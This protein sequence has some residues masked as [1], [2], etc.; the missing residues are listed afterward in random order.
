MLKPLLAAVAVLAVAGAL[1]F[2][3][4]DRGDDSAEADVQVIRWFNVSVAIPEGSGLS[5]LQIYGQN[6]RPVLRIVSSHDTALGITI[7]AETG[8][9]LRDTIM[10]E[11]RAAVDGLLKT[12][13]VS[14]LDLDTA[15][16]PYN[17]EPPAPR[18][19]WVDIVGGSWGWVTYTPPD[20][21]SGIT[22]RF[23]Q[24]GGPDGPGLALGFT[25]GR[26]TLSI[27][28]DTG[29]VLAETTKIAP[30]DAEAFDRLLSTVEYVGP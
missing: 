10:A 21:A 2:W 17:G 3:A 13:T 12:L 22:V 9:I 5:H 25:N 15:P 19:P 20:P 4:Y 29:T 7:D 18:E 6:D 16:W 30:E 28:A 1:A 14:P 11:D 24:G 23:Q 26:S 8:V 27:D